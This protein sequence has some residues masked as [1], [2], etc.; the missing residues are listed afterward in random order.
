MAYTPGELALPPT[1]PGG[2]ATGVNGERVGATN[3]APN[4]TVGAAQQPPSGTPAPEYKVFAPL[5][6]DYE[7]SG[8]LRYPNDP[9]TFESSDYMIFDFYNYAPPF[10]KDQAGG[11]LTYDAY[12]KSA[13]GLTYKDGKGEKKLTQV[14]LYMPEDVSVS[15]QANWDGKKFGNVAAGLL[16]SSGRAG[17]GNFGD[18]LKDLASTAS[19]SIK[20]A[21]TQLGASAVSAIVSGI[22]GESIS[23]NEIFSSVGGQ[24]LNPNTELIFG[25]Q[26]LRTFTFTY[27]LVAYN[28]AES[29]VIKNIISTFKIAM[30]PS[31]SA[32]GVKYEDLLKLQGSEFDGE[33]PNLKDNDQIGFIKNPLLVQPYFMH[34]TGVHGYLPRFKP[35]T[36][37]SFDVN[38]TADGVYAAYNDGAPVAA[39]ITI[40]LTETKLVY[41]EDIVRGF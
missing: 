5:S 15:Y 33:K 25:G 35:C 6:S 22:T 29:N 2:L 16:Q 26:D 19:G 23:S 3:V 27:K 20:R 10:G 30:L 11:G 9:S 14:I 39:T 32:D 28:Q 17:A 4:G 7:G 8:S 36:I 24:I 38:Y 41:A 21:P 31:F 13:T 1:T 12:N 34:K 18:A 40:S 37:T